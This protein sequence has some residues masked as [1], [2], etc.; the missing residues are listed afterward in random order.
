MNRSYQKTDVFT[1][2][3]YS[4]DELRVSLSHALPSLK[5]RRHGIG[6]LQAYLIE[7]Q[8]E[9]R[10]HIWHPSLLIREVEQSGQIHDHRFTLRSTVLFGKIE[11]HEY[12]LTESKE[13]S[14]VQ[15]TVMNARRGGDVS[16]VLP[17]L[18]NA[19]VIEGTI[20]TG[21]TYIFRRGEFHR[22]LVKGPA[23]TIVS[24]LDQVDVRARILVYRGSPVVHGFSAPQPNETFIQRYVNSAAE[25]LRTGLWHE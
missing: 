4:L 3:E 25:A 8:Q 9:I 21:Q 1:N 14:W 18:F 22:S 10:V 5:F 19:D 13:G 24:K 23:V 7:G 2:S 6:V 11:H 16:E 17:G 15:H 12:H 20:K